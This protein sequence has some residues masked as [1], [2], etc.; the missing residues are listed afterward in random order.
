MR[1]RDDTLRDTLIHL[2]RETC[3]RDGAEAI[4]IRDLARQAGVSVGTVY[5]YFAGKDEILLTLTEAYWRDTLRDMRKA[6]HS[7]S[8]VAQMREVYAFLLARM[9]SAGSLLM[10]SLRNVESVGRE[11]MQSMQNALGTALV[12]RMD[13][14]PAISDAIWTET[15]TKEGYADFI[16]MNLL[17][18][19]R[20]K[21]KD[22]GFFL[23]ILQRTL[24]R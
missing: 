13:A 17:L 19:L 2:A 20:A 23:E 11:R 18:L 1:K 15:F 21:A 7:T 14:D 16:L 22:I 4:N 5:N 10:G 24:Y 9:D 6:I 12:Q 3:L 8:F